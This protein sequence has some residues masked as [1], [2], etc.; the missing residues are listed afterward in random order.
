MA[1]LLSAAARAPERLIFAATFQR[2]PP[3]VITVPLTFN[4]SDIIGFSLLRHSFPASR[5]DRGIPF[6]RA[7]FVVES[8]RWKTSIF[9]FVLMC[10][11]GI[12][13]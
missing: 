12:Y 7:S 8:Q 5:Y 13:T 9:V 11:I 2:E 6:F 1:A 10:E 4:R 3:R